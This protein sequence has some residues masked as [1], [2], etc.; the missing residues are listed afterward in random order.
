MPRLF[1]L[2]DDEAETLEE[3]LEHVIEPGRRLSA[4]AHIGA[5]D[6]AAK[7][8]NPSRVALGPQ[9]DSFPLGFA[10]E[11]ASGLED[12]RREAVWQIVRGTVNYQGNRGVHSAAFWQKRYRLELLYHSRG[13]PDPVRASVKDPGDALVGFVGAA[14]DIHSAICH[15]AYKGQWLSVAEFSGDWPEIPGWVRRR[16]NGPAKRPPHFFYYRHDI[17]HRRQDGTVDEENAPDGNALISAILT[18]VGDEDTDCFQASFEGLRRA[19]REVPGFSDVTKSRH[20][21]QMRLRAAMAGRW[22]ITEARV[23]DNG[24]TLYEFRT[25]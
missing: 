10:E 21:F 2:D 20:R 14:E 8:R 4:K 18:I 1:G 3:I 7:L 24:V 6:L 15:G 25:R 5:I 12:L 19:L 23:L 11:I 16:A 9:S 17:T 22:T 13:V